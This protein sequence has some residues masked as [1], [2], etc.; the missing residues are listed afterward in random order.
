[1]R[2]CRHDRSTKKNHQTFPQC[3]PFGNTGQ[4]EE[5]VFWSEKSKV[6]TKEVYE[7]LKT[8]IVRP[9][10]YPTWIS[11]PV[12]VKKVER[13]WRMCIEF[14]NINSAC[15]KDYYPLPEID[16][17]IKSVVGFLLKCFLDAYKGY[18]QVQMAEEDAE[19]TAFYTDQ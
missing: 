9:V 8:G 17:K 10:K 7:W 5:E 13:G 12:L 14:K 1:M 15:P 2:A 3:Q 18:H 16:N 11:N 6:I 19:K 4:S